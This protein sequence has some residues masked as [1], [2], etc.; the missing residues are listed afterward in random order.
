MVRRIAERSLGGGVLPL[1]DVEGGEHERRRLDRPVGP[2]HDLVEQVGAARGEL[3]QADERADE[4]LR[5]HRVAA[6]DQSVEQGLLHVEG[7]AADEGRQRFGV[8]R[9]LRVGRRHELLLRQVGQQDAR[10]E[11]GRVV[12]DGHGQLEERLGGHLGRALLD[13]LGDRQAEL[14][15]RLLLEDGAEF[16]GRRAADAGGHLGLDDAG[17]LGVADLDLDEFVERRPLDL[18]DQLGVEALAHLGDLVAAVHRGGDLRAVVLDLDDRD[19][20]RA[21][22][23][24]ARVGVRRRDEP[25]QGHDGDRHG[26]LG[27][28]GALED[29]VGGRLHGCEDSFQIVR[30]VRH[31]P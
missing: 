25:E 29:G 16:L 4:R 31:V 9:L 11:V 1:A 6:L 19:V 27:A 28:T 26:D 17:G 24:R 20:G 3:A 12:A 10:V 30:R 5:L 18:D 7:L 2:L 15:R 13:L 8:D 14:G 23:G 21:R 22:A